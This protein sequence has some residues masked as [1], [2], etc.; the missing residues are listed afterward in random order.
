MSNLRNVESLVG[1]ILMRT[2]P[3]VFITIILAIAVTVYASVDRGLFVLVNI[4]VI[5]GMWALTATGLALG[6]SVMNIPNF[7]YG[8]FFML[9]TLVSYYMQT[10]FDNYLR[11]NPSGFLTF[12]SPVISIFTALV[13][14]VIAGAVVEKTIFY[15]MRKRNRQGWIMNCFVITIGLGLIM[16]NSHQ[17]LFGATLK[18]IVS[19]WDAPAVSFFGAFV[20]VERIFAFCLA[21]VAI[22]AFWVFF[23]FSK[24]G[25]A[26]RAVSMDQ[27]GSLMVGID[28]ELIQ[29]LTLGLSCGMAA[30][31]GGSLLFMFPS[32]PTVGGIPLFY[33]WFVIIIVGMGNIAGTIVGG[34][35][36]AL[37]QVVTRVY[38]GEGWDF[39][40]PAALMIVILLFIPS[41]IFGSKVRGI[42]DL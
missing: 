2:K 5:G 13:V 26:M 22:G 18:G 32:Y 9:G 41:G 37:L 16:V 29:T 7:A 8:E 10:F 20:S 38:A 42:W 36:V 11:N 21:L 25:Q 1:S 6:F 33:S 30:L 3:A 19:Y 4:L 40:V 27:A 12:L 34:F 28:Y 15:Q 14:G 35:I 17:L 24:Q 39:V 23:K 31:S